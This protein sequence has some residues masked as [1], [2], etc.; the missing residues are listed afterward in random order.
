MSTL[1]SRARCKVGVAAELCGMADVVHLQETHGNHAKAKGLLPQTHVLATSMC[2]SAAM[3]G[4]VTGI[5]KSWLKDRH[6]ESDSIIPGRLLRCRVELEA[7]ITCAMFHVHLEVAG[8]M[9][10]IDVL[11]RL[12]EAIRDDGCDVKVIIGD[13]NFDWQ[14][15]SAHHRRLRQILQAECEG[16]ACLDCSVPTCYSHG[17]ESAATLDH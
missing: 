13:F 11:H 2:T 9:S 7:D 3:G 17:L 6:W 16:F 1:P 14:A 15:R 12:T 4:L 5:R 8:E 10:Q